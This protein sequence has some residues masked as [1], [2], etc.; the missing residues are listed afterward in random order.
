MH[1]RKDATMSSPVP[2]RLR[3]RPLTLL[4]TTL[5]CWSSV[6]GS[7]LAAERA[8]EEMVVTATKRSSPLQHAA[9]AVTALD[10]H[11]LDSAGVRNVLDLQRTVPGM[12]FSNEQFSLS[13]LAI[14]GIGRYA[15]GTTSDSGAGIHL[16]GAY[17]QY[18]SA[19]E[20]EFYDIQRVEVLRGPQGTLYGRNTTAGVL[21]IIAAP[22]RDVFSSTASVELGD[23]GSRRLGGH[24]NLPAG[25]RLQLRIAGMRL[26]QDGF[27]R[28]TYS[29]RRVDD[30]D[31]WSMRFAARALLGDE[32]AL[33]LTHQRFEEDDRR[34]R[35]SKQYCATDPRPAPFNM[36]C[37]PG[38]AIDTPGAVNSL[39]QLSG[40]IP[41]LLDLSGGSVPG[42]LRL[43]PLENSAF[44]DAVVP[45]SAR[46]VH[47]DFDPQYRVEESVSTLELTHRGS[48]H[49]V[50]LIGSH[51][52][53][54]LDARTD[55][56]W[57]LP[58]TTFTPG[59]PGLTG[60]DGTLS[61]PADPT[62]S[63]FNFL[64]QYDRTSYRARTHTLEARVA[65]E[66]DDRRWDYLAGA[67]FMHSNTY[68]TLYDVHANTVA[69]FAPTDF[70]AGA[71][72]AFYRSDAKLYRLETAALFGEIYYHL[73]ADTRLTVG[74]RQTREQKLL[75]DRQSLLNTPGLVEIPG[76]SNRPFLTGEYAFLS[77][78]GVTDPRFHGFGTSSPGA[79]EFNNP[80]PSYRRRSQRWTELTGRL[81]IEHDLQSSYTGR[82][83]LYV[84]VAR[85]Y[86]S[87]GI[88]PASL[89]NVFSETFKPEYIN[90]VELGAKNR[91]ADGQLTLNGAYYFYDYRD[92]QI[93]K[94]IDRTSVNEN[95]DARIQGLE[96]ELHAAPTPGLRVDSSLALMHSRITGGS[97]VNP[98]DPTN[99]D[100]RWTAVKNP[101]G[102]V[103]LIPTPGS[104]ASF[105]E[106]DC[107]TRLECALVFAVNPVSATSPLADGATTPTVLVPI[108]VAA[109][110][111]GNRLPNA[112]TLSIRIGLEYSLRLGRGFELVPRADYAHQARFYY[113]VFNTRQDAVP[114]WNVIDLSI[115]LHSPDARWLARVFVSNATDAD[116]L[117]GAFLADA[118]AGG[119]TNVFLLDPRTL[120]ARV[121]YRF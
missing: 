73:H 65:S 80:V 25:E 57:A 72:V 55:L 21:N 4:V 85:S 82:T 62:V 13:T 105:A 114:S 63:G 17:L 119:Y 23:H 67:F 54:G 84:N 6:T 42:G 39:G 64:R 76:V 118:A 51:Q 56:D 93:S 33:T 37:L 22:P 104:G 83:M 8:I 29:G 91:L 38:H 45:T 36:G 109:S 108:G 59:I 49:A 19:L 88:N 7:A 16:N 61:T 69:A 77:W 3:N 15:V 40:M 70:Y 9:V 52:E 86:K 99:G 78:L 95:V 79:G 71:P 35:T 27:T 115:T 107:G 10:Q 101:S 5:A 81:G 20:A 103:Y 89:S 92:L 50:T 46:R 116:H 32:T 24:L 96:L 75:V 121:E 44:A 120:G 30:R 113:R 58:S 26:E 14:R 11:G 117:T 74:A 112:P 31:L 98:A 18:T 1:V 102:D 48:Q 34:M 60:T 87:G 94:M 111:S 2:G 43:L 53:I 12:L 100:V 66:F 110:L 90:S 41:A 28:N 97:S 47:A 106:A 68:D